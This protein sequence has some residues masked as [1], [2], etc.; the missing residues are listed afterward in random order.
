M[1]GY[2]KQIYTNKQELKL[3]NKLH[4][5]SIVKLKAEKQVMEILKKY[6]IMFGVSASML[7][8][9]GKTAR[10][11]KIKKVYDYD[12]QK[13]LVEATEYKL[14]IDNENYTWPYTLFDFEKKIMQVE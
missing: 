3:S 9:L 10:I 7:F 2:I 11:T 14:D 1:D 4:V 6:N 13:D 5:G 12:E 8:Y